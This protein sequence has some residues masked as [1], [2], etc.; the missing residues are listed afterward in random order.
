MNGNKRGEIS[1][2]K[3][4]KILIF[5]L[6]VVTLLPM[7]ASASDANFAVEAIIPDNQ[8]STEA[9]WFNLLVEPGDRQT[10]ELQ[11]RNNTDDD[12]TVEVD[13]A[14]AT[15][16]LNGIVEYRTRAD[17][18]RDS[19]LTHDLADLVTFPETVDVP[20]NG[21]A[22]LELELAVPNE[23]F[24]G[25]IAG[26]V[27]L[28]IQDSE[29]DEPD[30]E[31]RTRIRNRFAYEV[32]IT[33]QT[34]EEEMPTPNFVVNDARAGH[35]SARNVIFVNVQN[36]EATFAT[37]VS[38]NGRVFPRG[39]TVWHWSE[40]TLPRSMMFAPNSNMDFPIHL[41]A[42]M[43]EAGEYTACVTVTIEG[44]EDEDEMV[45][46]D[47]CTDFTIT[48]NQAH[49]FNTGD[50]D[51][52]DTTP[53][54]LIVLLIITAITAVGVIGAVLYLKLRERKYF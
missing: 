25:L 28:H 29:V 1:M 45:W 31:G 44:L 18:E 50:F 21:L 5:M 53:V 33:L 52:L 51:A 24:E 38:L 11:L 42:L 32:A 6:L 14:A 12:M 17:I 13:V 2:K 34:S 10:L 37:W 19:T 47:L 7:L 23:D 27:S 4:C 43:F 30:E 16:N 8:I 49:A 54:W 41:N 22:V 35:L 9:T 3:L 36:T 48:P 26:G 39:G 20:A 46:E 15:T 40:V